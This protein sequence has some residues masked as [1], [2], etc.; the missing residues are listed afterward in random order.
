MQNESV[1]V[2]FAHLFQL[3]MQ[4]LYFGGTDALHI[5]NTDVMEVRS[6]MLYYILYN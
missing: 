2:I 4:Y 1:Y 3:V 6:W 5:R